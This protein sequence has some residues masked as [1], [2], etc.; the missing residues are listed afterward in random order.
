MHNEIDYTE[1]ED[2][3]RISNIIN[4]TNEPLFITENGVKI[5]VI[6]SIACYEKMF[7]EITDAELISK[8]KL[9]KI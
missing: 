1:L 6:M 4:A 3:D 7:G 9:N 2:F 5:S 8:L